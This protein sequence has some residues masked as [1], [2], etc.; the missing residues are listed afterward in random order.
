MV[1]YSIGRHTVYGSITRPSEE[2]KHRIGEEISL[3]FHG[4]FRFRSLDTRKHMTNRAV[5]K[6][7]ACKK[8][9]QKQINQNTQ[10][11]LIVNNNNNWAFLIGTVDTIKYNLFY[12][13][14]TFFLLATALIVFH[15]CF[16][17]YGGM[18]STYK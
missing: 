4:M 7:K 9:T 10:C 13:L 8:K 1:K 17:C 5:D 18:F 12:N 3:L 6:R 14:S 2:T 16:S 11:K 15:F